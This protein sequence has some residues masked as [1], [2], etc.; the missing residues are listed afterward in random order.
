MFGKTVIPHKYEKELLANAADDAEKKSFD[1]IVDKITYDYLSEFISQVGKRHQ[2]A[3]IGTDIFYDS[4]ICTNTSFEGD[5]FVCQ[6]I[7]VGDETYR[8]PS[9]L[10]AGV[11]SYRDLLAILYYIFADASAKAELLLGLL[12]N[13]YAHELKTYANIEDVFFECDGET[14]EHMVTKTTFRLV[15]QAL[16]K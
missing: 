13:E 4:Y 15:Y 11:H 9:E 2:S 7:S 1:P 8:H 6:S 14:P 12:Y 5:V 16:R 3:P 10:F